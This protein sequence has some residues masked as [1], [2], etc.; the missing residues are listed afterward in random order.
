METAFILYSAT[1]TR[2]TAIGSVTRDGGVR[3]QPPPVPGIEKVTTAIAA[4][5][6]LSG[7]EV[8]KAARDVLQV[9]GYAEYLNNRGA[10][11]WQVHGTGTIS[12]T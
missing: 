12:T 9:A 1:Y 8:D 11:D 5:T 2:R 6:K 4:G 10:F 7:W 3:C